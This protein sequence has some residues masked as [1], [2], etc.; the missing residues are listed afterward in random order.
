MNNLSVSIGVH[1]LAR[2]SL[3]KTWLLFTALSYIT[4][5]GINL[6]RQYQ[7]KLI[8]ISML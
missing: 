6:K 2:C 4:Q 5:H 8:R 3:F 1:R 7:L